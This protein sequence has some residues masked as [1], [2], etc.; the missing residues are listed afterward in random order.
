MAAAAHRAALA[1]DGFQHDKIFR[2]HIGQIVATGQFGRVAALQG[3]DQRQRHAFFVHGVAAH[4]A[5]GGQVL[6]A[7]F[8]FDFRPQHA[9][10]VEQNHIVGQLDALLR[11]GHRRLIAHL[12][13]LAP[14]QRIDQRG[15]ADV[16]NAA[17]HQAQ[18]LDAVH[19]VRG[20]LAAGG[21]D[22]LLGRAIAAV[23]GNGAGV[24]LAGKPFQPGAGLCGVG[25][26]LLIE[27]F[28]AGLVLDQRGQHRVGRGHRQTGVHHFNHHV[29]IG[30]LVGQ[31]LLGLEHMAGKPLD[32]HSAG[33]F[34]SGASTSL[35]PLCLIS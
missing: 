22:F 6:A 13:H 20:Q 15:F 34:R 19:P 3:G 1:A 24:A 16:G 32:T 12:G 35:R 31:F 7:G 21:Q 25:Q 18:R 29:N 17:D 26:V 5:A 27:D 2:L 23:Q 14:G 30:Q 9:G 4:C 33:S 10:G 28:Q 8:V 11:L